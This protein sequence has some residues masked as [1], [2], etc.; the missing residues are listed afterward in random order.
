M[1]FSLM[2]GSTPS[3]QTLQ[4]NESDHITTGRP[5]LSRST[6]QFNSQLCT[7]L[8]SLDFQ[9]KLWFFLYT[10]LMADDMASNTSRKTN[11]EDPRFMRIRP[12]PPAS[13]LDPA[14]R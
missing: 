1:I 12:S 13:S 7:V 3:S 5:S 6:A 10:L 11:L 14:L 2:G 4:R 8:R 9:K